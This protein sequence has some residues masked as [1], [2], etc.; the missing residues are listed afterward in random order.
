MVFGGVQRTGIYPTEDK[1]KL[2]VIDPALSYEISIRAKISSIVNS[3]VQFGVVCYDKDYNIIGTQYIENGEYQSSDDG[4]FHST[5]YLEFLNE[6]LYYNLTGIILA[7]NERNYNAIKLNFSSGRALSF[8]PNAKFICPIFI[9]NRESNEDPNVYLYDIKIK[10]LEL[11][12]KQGYLG[13]KNVIAAYYKNNAFQSEN[14]IEIFIKQYLISYKNIL[15]GLSIKDKFQQTIIFK[16]F[17]ERNNYI[18]E[19]NNFYSWTNF[20]DWY[21]W[22]SSCKFISGSYVYSI[23]KDDFDTQEDILLVENFN[24]TKYI[25]LK[26]EFIK[27]QF[28]S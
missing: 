8:L 16:V 11:P 24:Y 22:W 20:K 19:Y 2:L 13:G 27:E 4:L 25:Q 21:K 10:P 3:K 23:E 7:Y 5:E 6:N 9:Q 15:G 26:V 28:L 12:F 17:S 1:S 18:Q 14:S